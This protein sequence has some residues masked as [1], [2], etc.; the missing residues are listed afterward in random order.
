MEGSWGRTIK[1]KEE[2]LERRGIEGWG[3]EPSKITKALAFAVFGATA[4]EM[5]KQ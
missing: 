5:K 2:W 4:I 1:Q 3:L